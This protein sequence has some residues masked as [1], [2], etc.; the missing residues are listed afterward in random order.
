VLALNEKEYRLDPSMTVIADDAQVHDIGGIMGGEHSGVADT[1]SDTLLEIAYFDPERIART[2]Q[3]L[4]LTSDARSRFERGVDPAFLD[5]GLAILTGLILDIC[6]G[7][8]SRVVRAGVAPVPDKAVKF[9]PARTLSLGGIDVPADRQQ[10]ILEGLGFTV[11]RGEAKVPSWRR[12]VDGPADLVEEVTRIAGYD[13]IPRQPCRA[14]KVS[15]CRPRPGRKLPSGSCA[16]WPPRAGS[17]KRS[18]GASFPRSRPTSSAAPA[19][20][21]P[22]RSAPT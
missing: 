13:R 14:P 16:A 21:S 22:T 8:A 19:T 20:S 5:D 11:A 6:G 1:T 3:K 2:G 18:T 15:H 12:D 7:E 9:D 17:M 10:A 4:Q